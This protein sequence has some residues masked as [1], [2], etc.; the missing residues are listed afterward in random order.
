MIK[1]H[2]EPIGFFI[3]KLQRNDYFSLAGFSDAEWFCMLVMRAGDTTALGQILDPVHGRKLR[4]VMERRQY[5]RRFLF[6]IPKV[7]WTLP[8]FDDGSIDRFLIQ[9]DIEIEAYERDLITDHL[10]MQADLYPLIAQLQKMDTVLIG[11]EAL[12]GMK[13][14]LFLKEFISV[15]SPN[16]HLE[17]GGIEKA[18]NDVKA[19]ARRWQL[20]PT[21]YL[22]SAGVSAAVIIDQLHDQIDCSWFIDC[23]SIWDAFVGI[24]S[25]REWRSQLYANPELLEQWK[26]YCLT[27]NPNH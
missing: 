19:Y 11:N 26:R 21:V 4:G 16:L 20:N 2:E 10:A 12:V 23:G 15:S 6:A 3:D 25:Q 17:A 1:I 14:I 22:I 13:E 27:G 9:H 24:G 18:V 8:N 7:L 5:D